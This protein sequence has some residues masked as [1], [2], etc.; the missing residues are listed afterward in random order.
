MQE[1][2]ARCS[3]GVARED[4]LGR[5]YNE[6]AF[7]YLL[8]TEQK[9]SERSG[10]PFLLLLL[11]LTEPAGGGSVRIDTKVAA[12]LFSSLE[13]GLRETDVVGWYREGRVAGALLTD[14]GH[15]PET[16]IP[17]RVGQRISGAVGGALPW[18][19]VRRLRVRVY[20]RHETPGIAS[21]AGVPQCSS[22]DGPVRNGSSRFQE[23]V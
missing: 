22:P 6:E 10:R 20:R 19:I 13:F 9:R 1:E 14:L 23:G 17:D 3:C 11:D 7:S 2:P 4:R 21:D 12:S 5:A 15:G 18:H 16:D 8:A